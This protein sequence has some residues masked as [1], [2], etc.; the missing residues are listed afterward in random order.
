M[1]NKLRSPTVAIHP[2]MCACRKTNTNLP[3]RRK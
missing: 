2:T 3:R 1:T